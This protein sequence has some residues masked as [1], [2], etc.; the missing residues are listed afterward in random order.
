MCIPNTNGITHENRFNKPR[1]E[2]KNGFDAKQD[3][4]NPDKGMIFFFSS[5][6][7]QEL[8]FYRNYQSLGIVKKL[9]IYLEVES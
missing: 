6:G 1:G 8:V 4:T 3:K 2:N 7:T 9:P 5:N